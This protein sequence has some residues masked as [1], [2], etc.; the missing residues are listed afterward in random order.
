MPPSRVN[1]IYIYIVVFV[2]QLLVFVPCREPATERSAAAF[3]TRGAGG[4]RVV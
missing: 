1:V 2:A 3:V 4:L